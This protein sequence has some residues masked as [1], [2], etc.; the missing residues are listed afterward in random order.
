MSTIHRLAL[1]ASAATL[2]LLVGLVPMTSVG[3][4]TPT[5]QVARPHLSTLPQPVPARAAAQWLAGQLSPQGFIP[6]VTGGTTPS[7]SDTANAVLA[8]S[9]A[10]VDPS[11]AQAALT[12]LQ[13]HVDAYVVNSGAD[14]PGQLAQLML[15]ATALG[16]SPTD[17]GGTNLVAR[18][19]A[20]QQTSGPDA[21]LFGTEDQVDAYAAGG[22]Q[23]GLALTALAG[24]GVRDTA[25]T[26]AA[27]AWLDAE[28]C[29]SGGWTLPDNDQNP[30]SGTPAEYEGP[31]TNTTSVA[32][33]GLAAQGALSSSV[34]AGA[35]SFLSQGQ[36][37]DAG[38]S[39]YPNSVAT[40]GVTDPNSTSLVIQGLLALGAS[41]TGATFTKG[42]VD[43]VDTLLTFQLASGVDS[44]AFDFNSPPVTANFLSTYQAVPALAGLTLPFGPSGSSYWLTG[45]DGGIFAFGG[46]GYYGSLPGLKVTVSNI[47]TIVSTA[48]G[49]GYWLAGT[50]G[51]IFGFGDAT[52]HGSLPGLSVHVSNIVGMVATPD[53]Q[54]YWQ[55]GSDGGVFAFGDAGFVGSLPGLSVH[56]NDIVGI[57]PTADGKG[58]WM[59]GADGGVFALGDAGYVGSLPGLS[60][61][62]HNIVGITPT[63]DG[64]GY[65]MVGADGGVFAFGDAGFIGS[66][67]A[68]QVSVNNIVGI[69]PTPDAQGYQL[70]GSNGGVYAF[71]NAGFSGSAVPSGA[72]DIVAIAASPARPA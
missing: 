38:W 10:N 67:P 37:T 56:V 12:Y 34:S 1:L 15:D 2:A 48:D 72:T 33:Q 50:D 36:D 71:G 27:V 32:V 44:G 14:G 66:L 70:A 64:K 58:Y 69:A 3:A 6:T 30:C 47:K 52:F 20:T 45:G 22:Y 63:A 21:G 35:L 62:V 46:A 18:L 13:A 16:V 57:V 23:Q 43:P 17:F 9:A 59:V 60:V 5:P 68:L 8:L 65:W 11:G 29:P 7:L 55:V 4:T 31:D 25:A 51:G 54:G 61:H 28:Q 24:A 41:P 53:G 26:N 39:Y 42:S 49:K 40:P 19:L